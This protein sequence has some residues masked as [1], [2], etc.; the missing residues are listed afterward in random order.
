MEYSNTIEYINTNFVT[1]NDLSRLEP[2]LGGLEDQRRLLE[3]RLLAKSSGLESPAPARLH[4]AKALVEELQ[5]IR[6]S[7]ESPEDLHP[8]LE[9]LMSKYGS[10]LVMRALLQSLEEKALLQT[11]V[12]Q[13][14]D[15]AAVDESILDLSDS[16]DVAGFEQVAQKLSQ[17]HEPWDLQLA[18]RFSHVVM[19]K[20]YTLSSALASS[21]LEIHWLS[22]KQD[23]SIN[24]SKLKHIQT[25]VGDML[26]LQVCLETPQYPGYWWALETLLEP[27]LVRF[28]F[29]F[30]DP[31]LKTNKI[32]KPEWALAFA[33]TFLAE[34]SRI[35][36]LVIDQSFLKYGKIGLLEVITYV[37]V[38][39]RTKLVSMVTAINKNISI[40]DTGDDTDKLEHAGRLLSHLI[41]ETASFDQKLRS[42]YK[43]NP[44]IT[45]LTHAPTKKWLG[46]TGDI[47]SDDSK[48]T[49]LENW[50]GLELRLAKKRFDDD[51]VSSPDAFE[52]DSDYSASSESPD[53]VLNPTYSAFALVKLFDNLTS[54]FKTLYIVKYQLKYVSKVQLSILHEYLSVLEKEFRRFNE[55]LRLKI[56][57]SFLPGGLAS[58]SGGNIDTNTQDITTNGL[59]GLEILTGLYCLAKFLIDKMEEWSEDLLFVQLWAYCQDTSTDSI[60][61]ESLKNYKNLC[62]RIVAKYEEFFRKEIRGALKN[63]VNSSVWNIEGSGPNSDAGSPDLV[64]FSM[65]IPPYLAYL[66]RMLPDVDYYIISSGICD[67]LASIILEYVITN[68][69]FTNAGIQQLQ[70]DLDHVSSIVGK[71]LLMTDQGIYSNAGNK[72]WRKVMQAVEMMKLIDRE[73]ARI[74]KKRFDEGASVRALF[75]DGLNCLSNSD[76]HDL[77]YRIV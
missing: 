74:F 24:S 52:I 76:I 3:E 14:Q 43:F 40:H 44:F 56:I 16:S 31:R 25:L 17:V 20:R 47:L 15:A 11:E 64:H 1:L 32:S 61:G 38:P 66:R 60:F 34:N 18:A 6:V 65:T 71:P 53:S 54:H 4:G 58:S 46:L 39:L 22:P 77:L 13:L 72:K 37:L 2:E 70:S 12:V 7:Q 9:S 57:S 73:G 5:Q 45:S 67:S 59:R 33:E 42:T 49:P 21:L 28:N 50:L 26:R 75:D 29:H 8:V 10:V 41:F 23:V 27:Y 62:T 63:Y 48:S 55:S 51:I 69:Q 68:N 35:L 36:E 19:A 30:T